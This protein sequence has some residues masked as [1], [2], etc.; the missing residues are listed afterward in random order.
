MKEPSTIKVRLHKI[1]T[2]KKTKKITIFITGD[3]HVSPIVSDR[4]FTFLKNALKNTKPNIIMLQGDMVDSPEELKRDS[5]VKKLIAELKLC[6][7]TAPTF[8][9]LGAHDFITTRDPRKVMKEFAI[10]KWR[11]IC[12]E[13]NV[14]LLMDEW[15]ELADMRIFGAFQDEKCSTHLNK[16]GELVHKD[17]PAEF[18]K[19]IEKFDFSVAKADK[20]NW[21]MAHAPL[22]T[23]K[24][25]EKC[26]AFDVMSFGHTHGGIVPRGMDEMFEKLHL[27]SGIISTNTT[28]FPRKVRGVWQEMNGTTIVINPGMTGAQFCAPRVW[29][30]MNFVK[31][32]EISLVEIIPED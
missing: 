19:F 3:W 9:V 24:V 11:Q 32:A 31:A 15:V 1:A 4:Q 6:S 12:K 13:C 16:K 14:K 21:L 18:E 23:P 5:S 17:S 2:K 30:E 10:P 27:H 8:L 25:L 29:Q 7:Q 26:S 22:F 28:L 20:I